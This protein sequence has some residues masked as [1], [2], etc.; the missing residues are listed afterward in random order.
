MIS[1]PLF[2]VVSC[3]ALLGLGCLADGSTADCAADSD[4]VLGAP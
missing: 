2:F 1:R 4:D 3:A